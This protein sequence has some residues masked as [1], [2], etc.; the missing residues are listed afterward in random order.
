M[1]GVGIGVYLELVS[2]TTS[3][4]LCL[5]K[6]SITNVHLTWSFHHCQAGAGGLV[7]RSEWKPRTG[8]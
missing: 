7:N 8:R 1:R 6:V 5:R 3:H 2:E 4:F